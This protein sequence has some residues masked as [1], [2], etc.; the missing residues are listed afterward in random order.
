MNQHWYLGLDIATS[1]LSAVLINGD[2]QQQYPL[3]WQDGEHQHFALPMVVTATTSAA[4][5]WQI[6][7]DNDLVAGKTVEGWLP[8]LRLAPSYQMD[9][10]NAW[11]PT[12]PWS[13]S[14]ELPL[15][16][17]GDALAFLLCILKDRSLTA[18]LSP[19]RV[20]DILG[21]LDGVIVSLPSGWGDTY[22]L[23]IREVLHQAN[24]VGRGE[25]VLFVPG[26]IATLLGFQ[27]QLPHTEGGTL[28]IHSDAS[29]TDLAVV[30]LP[31]Y[32]PELKKGQIHTHSFDYGGNAL[33]QDILCQ[34]IYPQWLPQLQDTLSK[35]AKMMP[36]AGEIDLER[37]LLAAWQWRNSPVG[38]S[39]LQAANQTKA[40]LQQRE[41]FAAHLGQQEWRVTRTDL[42][43][44]IIYPFQQQLNQQI[45]HLF[46]TAGVMSQGIQ[47]II[48]SGSNLDYCWQWLSVSL[49]QK[50]PQA[51]LIR[52]SA[53]SQVSRIAV[54]LGLVPLMPQIVD[55][56]RHRYHD[57]FLL[58]TLLKILP[59][60]PFRLETLSRLLQAEGIN[61]R[62]CGDRL[63]A[64]LFS[65]QPAGLAPDLDEQQSNVFR[66]YPLG[67]T[68][69][70]A[71][72][73]QNNDGFYHVHEAQREYFL[74]FWRY[75]ENSY[76]IEL[77][78]PYRLPFGR[79][80]LQL[81]SQNSA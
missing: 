22:R 33:Q 12:L 39:L 62:H 46:A 54:G 21:R 53:S 24:L 23:N 30:D 41:E 64:L 37:R 76:D 58:G 63:Q 79:S 5:P 35:L 27:A 48:C 42:E 51:E 13:K 25:Q 7:L 15:K 29:H 65:Q 60:E 2:R 26:A 34:L 75:F 61:P 72:C 38:R 17:L 80:P 28:I 9:T 49:Q 69:T 55:G 43:R 81:S 10:D 14:G 77:L 32:L 6:A 47:Q 50:F 3:F 70:T 68:P 40:L 4:Q 73:W 71:L 67:N 31:T 66:Q 18:E 19:T 52:D 36:R 59:D 11:F 8:F 16:S 44:K 56:D 1:H 45:N 20:R 78:E 57:Y 74:E